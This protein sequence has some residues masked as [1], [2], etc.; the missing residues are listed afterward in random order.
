MESMTNSVIRYIG[1]LLVI[2]MI[3]L[4]VLLIKAR[5]IDPDRLFTKMDKG[6]I[7]C[8]A[9]TT[10]IISRLIHHISEGSMINPWDVILMIFVALIAFG[11]YGNLTYRIREVKQNVAVGNVLFYPRVAKITIM[12]QIIV[13]ISLSFY[14]VFLSHFL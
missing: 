12:N 9:W 8:H 6:I 5:E 13:I 3:L 4:T 7:N 1:I 2:M 14:I 11:T 10:M